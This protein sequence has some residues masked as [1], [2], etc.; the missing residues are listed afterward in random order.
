MFLFDLKLIIEAILQGHLKSRI[1]LTDASI[2]KLAAGTYP[3][4]LFRL[5][6]TTF[7]I[8]EGDEDVVRSGTKNAL[9]DISDDL[10]VHADIDW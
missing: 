7:S 4:L 8:F 1:Y 10:I 3:D 5:V 9:E 6:T 2:K